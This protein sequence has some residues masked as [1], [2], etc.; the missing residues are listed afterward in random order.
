MNI[1]KAS[2]NWDDTNLSLIPKA[3]DISGLENQR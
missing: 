2:E 3:V 1:Q